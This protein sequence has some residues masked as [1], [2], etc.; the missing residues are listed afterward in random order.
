MDVLKNYIYFTI[1]LI[2][3]PRLILF[4]IFKKLYVPVYVQYETLKEYNIKTII[5]VG[6]HHGKVSQSLQFIFPNAKIYAFEPDINNHSFIL[7]RI[8]S[9]KLTLSPLALSNKPGKNIFY[10][11]NNS[12]VSSLLPAQNIDHQSSTQK[13][14]VET[15][16][17]DQ[18]FKNVKFKSGVLLKVDTQGTEGLVLQGGKK[19]LKKV[20]IIHIETSFDRYYKD[21]DL[22]KDV[23]KFLDENGFEYRG[24]LPEAFFY[25]RFKLS[26]SFNSVFMKPSIRIT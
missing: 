23:Y 13:S 2:L 11:H 26:K 25:P 18:Y 4:G 17:L 16:T 12:A 20:D 14:L 24:E 15:S 22:F 10:K 1:F 3:N 6:A 5:D 7:D 9:N 21:Q 19:I 8:K